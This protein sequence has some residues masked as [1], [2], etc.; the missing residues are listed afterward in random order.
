MQTR[1]ETIQS[2]KEKREY[3][4][5]QIGELEE[6]LE[7]L[8]GTIAF[9]EKEGRMES[10]EHVRPAE[11]REFPVVKLHGLTQLQAVVMIAKHFRG[12]VK[13]QDAKR[14]MING[15][16]M[17][18]TKNST[19]I[20]HNLIIRSKL[21]ERIAPGEYRLKKS[22]ESIHLTKN[23]METLEEL[24]PTTKALQAAL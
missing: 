21:F 11:A 24:F 16:V 10:T 12:V 9:L 5:H 15:G 8:N 3:V 20:T 6:A 17:K 22:P 1:S 2:L 4:M 23:D 14:L 7:C 13:A 19:N 18:E